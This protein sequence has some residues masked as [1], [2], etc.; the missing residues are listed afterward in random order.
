MIGAR[1]GLGLLVALGS[2]AL[3]WQVLGPRPA[4]AESAHFSSSQQCLGCHAEVGA[5]WSASWHSRSW[6]DPDVRAL[7]NDFAN[8]DCIDCHAPRPVFETGVDQRVLP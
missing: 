1:R 6:T 3:L 2:V 4:P 5:E 8:T 7:S